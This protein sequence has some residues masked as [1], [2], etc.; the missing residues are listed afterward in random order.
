MQAVERIPCTHCGKRYKNHGSIWTHVS[1]AHRSGAKKLPP[2]AAKRK[3]SSAPALKKQVKS[4]RAN[5]KR[6]AP[7]VEGDVARTNAQLGSALRVQHA[8]KIG[9]E[10]GKAKVVAAQ[11]EVA[12]HVAPTGNSITKNAHQKNT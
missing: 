12:S 6:C 7:P 2:G 4:P 1:R 11:T 8:Y 9:S 3:A 10:V 5:R